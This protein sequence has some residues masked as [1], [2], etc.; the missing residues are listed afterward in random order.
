MS[1]Y[2]WKY[3]YCIS[4]QPIQ[5]KKNI[6]TAESVELVFLNDILINIYEGWCLFLHVFSF[7][8][9]AKAWKT[10]GIFSFISY[11]EIE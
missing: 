4:G 1:R 2:G 5:R 11:D 7:G 9:L 3:I 10:M 6:E 8:Q